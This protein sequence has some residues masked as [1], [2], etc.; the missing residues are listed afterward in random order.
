MAL[1]AQPDLARRLKEA[2]REL[3][4]RLEHRDALLEVLRATHAA[5]T[6]AAVAAFLVKW[7]PRWLPVSRWA[8]LSSEPGRPLAVLAHSDLS[9]DLVSCVHVVAAGVIDKVAPKLTSDASREA[10]GLPSIAVLAFPLLARDRSIGALVGCDE[11]PSAAE[12]ELG[13]DTLAAWVQLLEAAGFALDNAVRLQ[14]AEALSVT[15]DLTRLYNS[16]FLNEALRRETKRALRSGKPL[17]LLFLDLDGFKDVNDS[18]GHLRGSRAL[19]E[20]AAVIKGSA[21]ETDVVARF[22]GDEFALV[23]P[24][25]DAVGAAAVAARVRERIAAHHFLSAEHLDIRLTVSVGVATLPAHGATAEDLVNAAD[26]AMYSVKARGKNGIQ[27]FT[28]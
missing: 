19:V 18:H 16:R 12:P 11:A 8:V 13:A 17:S 21:R 28:G 2:Q 1:A 27:L 10:P 15:D 4:A 20:A 9:P 22:G 25:T 7:A 26:L 6:A 23:L 14:R 5:P 3:R 24:D